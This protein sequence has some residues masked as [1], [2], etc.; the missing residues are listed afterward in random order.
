M[1][2]QEMRDTRGTLDENETVGELKIETCLQGGCYF[3]YPGNQSRK[4]DDS[5]KFFLDVNA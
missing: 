4:I 3:G 1:T 5:L 2:A